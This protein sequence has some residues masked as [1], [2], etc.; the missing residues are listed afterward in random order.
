MEKILVMDIG[1]TN[2]RCGAF[3]VEHEAQLLET[4]ELSTE[5]L[6]SLQGLIRGL[7]DRL[8]KNENFGAAIIGVAGPVYRGR[9]RPPNIPFEIRLKELREGLQIH[10]VALLND[11]VLYA[12]FCLFSPEEGFISINKRPRK[13]GSLC[14]MAPGTGF[15]VAFVLW[16]SKDHYKIVPSEGGHSPFPFR[17]GEESYLRYLKEQ[18]IEASYD[19]VVSGKGIKRLYGFLNGKELRSEDI[20]EV[21]SEQKM[22]SYAF[23]RFLGRAARHL[24]LTYLPYGGLF[25]GGGVLMKNPHLVLDSEFRSEFRDSQKMKGL[26]RKIPL[27]LINNPQATLWGGA[28]LYLN[29]KKNPLI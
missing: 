7:K 13:R 28:W 22:L 1:G 19:T 2:V 24:A 26:L 16:L 11:M 9:T 6:G 10:D 17:E 21:L 5:K 20:S 18:G 8:P 29:S 25:L 27:W 12:S 4:Y 23:S 14:I 15:G 3:G